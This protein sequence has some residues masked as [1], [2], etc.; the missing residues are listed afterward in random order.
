MFNIALTVN[1]LLQMR[2][3]LTFK[4]NCTNGICKIIGTN[5]P[6]NHCG[7][8]FSIHRGWLYGTVC[9]IGCIEYAKCGLT[10]ARDHEWQYI[11]VSIGKLVM[12]FRDNGIYQH[13]AHNYMDSFQ[14]LKQL[15]VYNFPFVIRTVSVL[16]LNLTSTPI[17]SDYS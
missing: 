1:D 12:K 11:P 6:W 14:R 17:T 3:I 9:Y 4:I 8:S 13:D 15:Y 16:L 7:L 2:L 10:A 5:K